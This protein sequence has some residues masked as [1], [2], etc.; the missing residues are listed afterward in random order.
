LSVRKLVLTGCVV[1]LALCAATVALAADPTA[2]DL[3]GMA[4]QQ[5]D[6]A[7]SRVGAQRTV[8]ATGYV[9]GYVRSLTFTKPYGASLIVDAESEVDIA[10]TASAVTYDLAKAER[11]FRSTAGR[12]AIVSTVVKSSKTV[13]AKDVHLSKVRVV[14]I[15]DRTFALDLSIKVGKTT[16]YETFLFSRLDRVFASLM[17]VAAKPVRARE[18][19]ALASLVA[20]H[21][22]AG[23][24]P[25]SLAPPAVT[26]TAQQGQ[27]LSVTV[28]SWRN[29][30][31]VSYSWQRCDAAGAN[32]VAIDG[33]T[34]STYAVAATDAGTTLRVVET[35]TNRFGTA[36]GTSVQT[37][38]VV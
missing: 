14:A 29:T 25:A 12:A 8:S 30:G 3:A 23:L 16:V 24:T 35:T 36:S 4:L 26:G 15:G 27:T 20:K 34:T 5:T 13:K 6:V 19:N 9:A 10:S 17:L 1:A 37:A 38:V 32:C 21:V 18:A 31:T 7:G 22:A 28:G 11:A 33:A 2:P